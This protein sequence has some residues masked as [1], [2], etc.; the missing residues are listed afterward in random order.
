MDTVTRLSDWWVVIVA[1][2]AT[3]QVIQCVR[4]FEAQDCPPSHIL[5]VDNSDLELR[6]P[7]IRPVGCSQILHL[8]GRD[9]GGANTGS[10][11]GFAAG[12]DY[13][14]AH[15]AKYTVLSD[16]DFRPSEALLHHLSKAARTF[17]EA[18]ISSVTID[19]ETNRIMP[20]YLVSPPGGNGE[21]LGLSPNT[22]ELVTALGWQVLRRA[23]L[24]S[25]DGLLSEARSRR[26]STGVT[27][28]ASPQ[29]LA[30][31]FTAYA[32]VGTF[33]REFFVGLDDY[34]YCARL[35]GA[36]IP[37]RVALK[38]TGSHHLSWHKASRVGP[39]TV[40]SFN[41][42]PPRMYWALRNSLILSSE[43]A[44]GR[45]RWRWVLHEAYRSVTYAV[46]GPTRVR[47][48][49]S[50]LMRGW[51]DGYQGRRGSR[52]LPVTRC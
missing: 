51:S 38:S 4:S 35:A 9:D 18:V 11:G 41:Q 20:A 10:A 8:D 50:S 25:Y 24:E 37:I 36:R 14:F 19:P 32:K 21:V 12:L 15:G 22:G 44:S 43:W 2:N 23:P 27:P 28:L 6:I 1:Y 33:R 42:S 13:A 52:V 29:G 5:I 17:P 46:F 34:D 47:S 40:R 39:L 48:R 45:L 30:I 16:Q 26:V 7:R 3:C 49:M 31:P